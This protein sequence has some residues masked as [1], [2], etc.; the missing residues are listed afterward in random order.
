MAMTT[1]FPVDR[2]EQMKYIFKYFLKLFLSILIIRLA[3]IGIE[4]SY[5]KGVPL[6]FSMPVFFIF[7]LIVLIFFVWE[8][9]SIY[10]ERDKENTKDE[11]KGE[12]Q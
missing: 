7:G 4:I 11:K 2:G 9:N 5:D 10:E 6:K 8:I 1:G 3:G 12:K